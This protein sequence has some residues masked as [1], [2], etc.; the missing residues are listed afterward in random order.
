MNNKVLY[1]EGAGCEGADISKNTIGNCRIRTA[2]TNND[3]RAIYI[4]MTAYQKTK[5]DK[6]IKRHLEYNVGD[7]IGFVDICFYIDTDSKDPGNESRILDI[8]RKVKI[9]YTKEGITNMINE[10]LNCNFD[11]IEV[12]PNLAGYRVHGNN[13]YNIMENY[14]H[15]P[16]LIEKR[17]EI[18]EYFYNL[19]KEEG[20]KYPNFSLW[21]DEKERH[22]LHLLRHF[23][24]YNKHWIIKTNIK[25]WE[26]SIKE[27]ELGLYGC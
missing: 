25:N 4:E 6:K 3:G 7:Y 5:Y 10:N 11:T 13:S 23:N 8:E 15:E 19:E 2:F 18:K 17:K 16:T 20:K 27:S 24:G 9:P 26:K 21:V 22:I 12:L 1:F 14:K